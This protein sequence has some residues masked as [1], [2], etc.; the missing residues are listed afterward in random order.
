MIL[1][2][3]FNLFYMVFAQIGDVYPYILCFGMYLLCKYLF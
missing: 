3:K 1:Y 2:L